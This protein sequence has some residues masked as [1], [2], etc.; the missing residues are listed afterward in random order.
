MIV[1]RSSPQFC[2]GVL[3]L[4]F[5]IRMCVRPQH[6]VQ[7]LL[8]LQSQTIKLIDHRLIQLNVF[9]V[10]PQATRSTRLRFTTQ[11]PTS[12]R[13]VGLADITLCRFND[14]DISELMYGGN[15]V[16]EWTKDIVRLRLTQVSASL[17][18]A[19]TFR[20]ILSLKAIR[21]YT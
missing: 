8:R 6:R 7:V 3:Y 17:N 4:G 9:T 12:V 1:S 10:N 19:L 16:T 21:I 11:A 5:P 2:S 14:N 13:A 18:A 20:R 15:D